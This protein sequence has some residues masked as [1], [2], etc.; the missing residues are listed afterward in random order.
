MPLQ[1]A[2]TEMV[3][4]VLALSMW[5]MGWRLVWRAWRC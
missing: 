3:P 4:T 1:E 5:I 2:M